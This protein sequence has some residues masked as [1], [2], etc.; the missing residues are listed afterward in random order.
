MELFDITKIIFTNP[1][2]W[3]NVTPGEKRKNFFLLNRRFAVQYPMQANA[4]QHNKIN[5]SAVIDF[6]YYFL[7]KQYK[8][9]PHWMFIKGVKKAKD[10]KEKKI[11][12]SEKEIDEYVKFMKVD[13]KS[14]YDAIQFYPDLM[15]S[16]LKS[17]Q[18]IIN[19]K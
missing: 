12:I 4:L 11:N 8:T 6:W 15:I 16:E 14:I 13:K 5:Q 7:K 18:K 9:T 17:F 3:I 2:E 19:Q 1:I 10:E